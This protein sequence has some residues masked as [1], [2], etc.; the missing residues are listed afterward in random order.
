[1]RLQH[2]FIL[3]TCDKVAVYFRIDTLV[4]LHGAIR[5]HSLEMVFSES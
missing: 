4:I 5:L 1:M 2:F 3:H